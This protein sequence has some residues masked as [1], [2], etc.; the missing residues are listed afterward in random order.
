MKGVVTTTILSGEEEMK[1]EYN[2][3]SIDIIK[4]VNKIPIA[5]VI[6]LDGDAA[7][8][9]F[10]I[11]NTD[12]FKPGEKVEIK[13]RYEGEPQNEATVFKGI[14]VRHCVQADQCGSFLTI[15]L[16]DAAYKLTTQRKSVVF[17]DMTDKEIIDKI[18]T[19]GGLE[20]TSIAATKPHHK[21]M[22]QYYCTDW[23]FI[24]SRAD[25]NGLW[26]LAD[27]G[28]ITVDKPNLKGKPKPSNSR[29]AQPTPS[30]SEEGNEKL[31]KKVMSQTVLKPN[32]IIPPL[33]NGDLLTRLE[34]E[35]R[36]AQMPYVKKAELIEGKVYMASPLR[37]TQHAEPHALIMTW[38][39]TYWSATPGVKVGD[40]ATVRLD[41]DN[42]PQPDALL[43]IT[44]NGQSTIS[45]DGYVEGAPELIVE[46]AASTASIDLN[47]KLK[48]YR[49]NQVQEYLVWR[50]YDGELDWF[51]LREGK[52]LKLQ[53]SEKGIICSDYFPGLWL[54]QEALLTGDLAQVLAV[55]QQGLNSPEHENLVKKLS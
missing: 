39:G 54:T 26:V 53:P 15:D 51:R 23:D 55:L 18:I 6:L 21:E 41:G 13:L 7:K 1:P 43:R 46:I 32:K 14:I 9:E 17:R 31:S 16:K 25:V 36:Y 30:P 35:Q 52:Y 47:D 10:A 22:V 48:V 28:K 49:R 2:V 29:L 4:E 40:N 12:F 44:E 11:S 37:F 33:E 38:L 8:Q 3:M 20:E 34:F 5:Q 45:E 24:L 42:E 19:T 50:V 27:D